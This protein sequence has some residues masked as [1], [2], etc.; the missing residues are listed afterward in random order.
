MTAPCQMPSDGRGRIWCDANATSIIHG[1]T[2]NGQFGAAITS[3]WDMSRDTF[4]DLFI[5][6]PKDGVGA[7][8]VFFC[9]FLTSA[10][11]PLNTNDA[12]AAL[13]SNEIGI[14]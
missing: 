12:D 3:N 13:M 11:S 9:S 4:N 10:T 7:T 14:T 5:G 1:L 6:V 8:H 2:P